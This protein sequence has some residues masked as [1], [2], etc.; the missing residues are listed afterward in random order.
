MAKT[1][2]KAKHSEREN[3][4]KPVSDLYIELSKHVE[5][6]I[7]YGNKHMLHMSMISFVMLMFFR[8]YETFYKVK[9][10]PQC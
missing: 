2:S 5:S 6:L 9:K 8:I 3:A 1:K 4:A 7:F 10:P